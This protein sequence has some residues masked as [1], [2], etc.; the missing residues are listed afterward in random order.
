MILG[1]AHD[2]NSASTSCDLVALR[3]ALHRIVLTLGMKVGTDFANE[4]AHIFFWKHNDGIHIRQRRQNFRAF[5]GRHHGAP[6]ALQRAHGSIGI[7]RDDQFAAEFPRG[8]QVAHVSD[9]QQVETS[10]GQCD[11]MAGAPPIR[12][13][14]PQFVARNNL[15]IE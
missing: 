3:N 9:M 2:D 14:L 8:M 13:A 7:D 12:D 4:G 5:L 10:V 15:R 11:G 1:I 6:F